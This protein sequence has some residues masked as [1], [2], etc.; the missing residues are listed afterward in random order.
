MKLIHAGKEEEVKENAG[1]EEVKE[2]EGRRKRKKKW[3]NR[4]KEG[5]KT[6]KERK[7]PL[8]I[9][10]LNSK[11]NGVSYINPFPPCYLVSSVIFF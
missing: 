8:T 6:E 9:K 5:K 7:K 10:T 1:K 2:K 3:K 4:K 11:Q